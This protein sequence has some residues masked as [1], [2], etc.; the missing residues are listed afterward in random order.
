MQTQE[1]ISRVVKLNRFFTISTALE[2]TCR[3]LLFNFED[4]RHLPRC[5]GEEVEVFFFW[6]DTQMTNEEL[7]QEYEKRGL[8]PA[9]LYS[10]AKVNQDYPDFSEKYPNATCWKHGT[11]WYRL[12]FP[13]REQADCRL[14]CCENKLM[15]FWWIAGV[16]K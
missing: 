4:V 16:R 8:K 3:N 6:I 12:F 9:D 11:K 5:S 13:R 1:M 2:S 15:V 14:S 7:A 10:L